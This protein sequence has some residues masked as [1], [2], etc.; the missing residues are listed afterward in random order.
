LDQIVRE[1]NRDRLKFKKCMR[2]FENKT[3]DHLDMFNDTSDERSGSRGVS[4]NLRQS[5]TA[6]HSVERQP[7]ILLS[8]Q[9]KTDHLR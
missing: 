2:E 3:Y 8:D 1:I 5:A 7:D 6:E 4:A 9:A